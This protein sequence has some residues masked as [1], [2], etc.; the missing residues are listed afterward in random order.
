MKNIL[1]S[2]KG[3]TLSELVI[4]L[5]VTG[6]IKLIERRLRAGDRR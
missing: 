2:R 3:A 5:A 1:K 4:V 6:V